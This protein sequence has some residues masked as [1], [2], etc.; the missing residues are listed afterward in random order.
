MGYV[1]SCSIYGKVLLKSIRCLKEDKKYAS[2]MTAFVADSDY[3]NMKRRI[4]KVSSSQ[5]QLFLNSC[6]IVE[7]HS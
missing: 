2:D 6:Y 1:D 5:M 4:K 7:M 3:L